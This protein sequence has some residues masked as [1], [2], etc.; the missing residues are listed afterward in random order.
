VLRAYN[1][2]HIDEWAGTYPGRIIPDGAADL[3]DADLCAEEVRRVARKGCHSIT[4]TENPHPGLSQ[5]PQQVLGPAVEGGLGGER[6]RLDPPGS[7]GQLSS[8][9]PD[10]PI[11]RI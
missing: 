9:A 8:T 3:W 11:E 4:F 2:W 1:D 7:S 5:F 6:R 10:A